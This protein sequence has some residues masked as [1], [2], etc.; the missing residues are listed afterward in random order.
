[1]KRLRRRLAVFVATGALAAGLLAA[2]AGGASADYG[3][4]ALY[5]VEITANEPGPTGGGIWLWIE[6]TPSGGSTTSGTGDYAGSDCG[7]GH[8]SARDLGDVTW[9]SAGG[10]LTI[11]G[12]LLHGFGP[13]PVPVT[14]TVPS[15]YGHYSY[16]TNAFASIFSG[17]P[18]FV[19]GGSAQVQV[20]P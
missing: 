9:S 17:L 2:L 19:T 10:T 1:M 18:P 4:G 8:G 7:H 12:V 6:L 5:Q 15:T 13:T 3:P 16:P 20:A 14:I 11:S